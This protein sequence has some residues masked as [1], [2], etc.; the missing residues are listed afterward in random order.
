MSNNCFSN[1]DLASGR[2]T[3]S[4]PE[5][6]FAIPQYP[7]ISG[8]GENSASL[9]DRL[10][11]F[12]EENPEFIKKFEEQQLKDAI[13][14]EESAMAYWDDVKK[15]YPT[16]QH[17]KEVVSDDW[18]NIIT[19]VSQATLGMDSIKESSASGVSGAPLQ[20]S[21]V[22]YLNA[23]LAKHYG[24]DAAT[25][26]QEALSNTAYQRSVEDMKRA[27]LN[28]ASIFG[29]GRGSTAGGVGYVGSGSASGFGS[30]NDDFALTKS[31]YS[32]LTG[33]GGVIAV[34]LLKGVTNPYV[35]F[36]IGTSA[37][38]GIAGFI[39]IAKGK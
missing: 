18:H 16:G 1:D 33:L 34:A 28:P 25:A 11:K 22:D 30:S 19:N 39:G 21:T 13:A 24:M 5:A 17:I 14:A 31:Q 38:K 23:N 9:V 7:G 10:N 29:A 8:Q 37:A 2:D 26:Y 36:L 15:N 4:N 20:P 3:F 27:G 12:K 32:L 6:E 35:R